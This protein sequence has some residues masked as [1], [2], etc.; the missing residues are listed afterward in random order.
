[1]AITINNKELASDLIALAVMCANEETDNCDITL[2]TSKGKI[3]CHIEF[4]EVE[5]GNDI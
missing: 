2:T 4:S 3:N 5:D 1:M